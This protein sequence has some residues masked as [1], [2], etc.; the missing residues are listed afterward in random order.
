MTEQQ[1]QNGTLVSLQVKSSTVSCL[2]LLAQQSCLVVLALASKIETASKQAHK[3]Q[4]KLSLV[5]TT[6]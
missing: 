1:Y 5:A 2:R 3:A 6:L 4:S